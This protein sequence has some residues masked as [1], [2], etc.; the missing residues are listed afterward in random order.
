MISG[1]KQVNKLT[2]S[3]NC[4]AD[5][6][7]TYCVA[8]SFNDGA[9]IRTKSIKEKKELKE[10]YRFKNLHLYLTIKPN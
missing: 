9:N 6:K 8:I 4:V 7:F 10:I 3:R 5:L 1:K 2:I